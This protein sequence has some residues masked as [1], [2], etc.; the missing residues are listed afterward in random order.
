VGIE[1]RTFDW[2]GYDS[3]AFHV[4]NPGAP[5]PL[6]VR[7]DDDGD[8][9]RYENRYNG[10]FEVPTGATDIA[11]ALER[12]ASAPR[13]RRLELARIRKLLIFTEESKEPRVF[14]IDDVRV[15]HA[16]G[17]GAPKR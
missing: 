1:G 10:R 9:R 16:P 3:L 14:L 7:V 2:S 6:T 13:A 11:V 8:C 4:E 17:A 12:I 5:L 15:T